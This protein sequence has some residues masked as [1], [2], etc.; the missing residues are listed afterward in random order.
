MGVVTT[1]PFPRLETGTTRHD[2]TRHDTTQAS[3]ID[4][5]HLL[6]HMSVSSTTI[7]HRRRRRHEVGL[8]LLV[9]LR[10][11]DPSLATLEG[12]PKVVSNI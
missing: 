6:V 8:G 12:N 3:A 2:T 5:L 7:N 11:N 1:S 4:C 10:P 9:G